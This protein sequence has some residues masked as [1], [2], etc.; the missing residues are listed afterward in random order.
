MEYNQGVKNKYR[1]PFILFCVIPPLINFLV[2]YVYVNAS[3]ILMGFMNSSG[4]WTL[5][6]FTRLIMEFQSE[7]SDIVLGLKNTFLTFAIVLISYPFKV[8]VS[9]FI[10]K[11]V[12]FSG[13]YRIAFFLPTI[14]FSVCTAMVFQRLVGPGGPIAGAVQTMLGLEQT[15]ELLA[16]SKYANI[17]II[18]HMLWLNFPGDLILWGGNFAKIPVEVLEA[19]RVDGTSWFT[20]FT[21]IIIPMVWPLVALQMVMMFANIFGTS[22]EV[23]LLTEGQY[24]TM[25][26]SAW[27]YLTLIRNAGSGYHS[28]VYNYLSAVG[29][30]TTVIAITIALLVKKFTDKAFNDI[31]I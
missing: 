15:P 6:N 11:K 29:L 22:G 30:V 12:P 2:F 8:L 17:T 19:G 21:R 9:Y 7:S 24:G 20:E 23:F 25:T 28:N 10:Y 1:I 27:M 16:D 13:F 5:D 14:V 3:S 4:Q 31:E 18:L 26:L